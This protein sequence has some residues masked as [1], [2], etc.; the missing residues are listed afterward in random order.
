MM[1]VYEVWVWECM[2]FSSVW[3]VGVYDNFDD[4]QT[5]CPP[6]EL[7]SC[8]SRTNVRCKPNKRYYKDHKYV[9]G[10]EKT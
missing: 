9:K 7:V 3:G 4:F 5:L 1:G 6:N 10:Y 8:T 2:V